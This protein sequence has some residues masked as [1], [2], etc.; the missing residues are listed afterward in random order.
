MKIDKAE[1]NARRENLLNSIS[2]DSV[3]ILASSKP[4]QRVSDTEY[5]Y[6]QDSNFYYLCGFD[7]PDSLIESTVTLIDSLSPAV[8]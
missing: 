7:E 5:S 3:I 6:R 2:P 4:K 1:F 8:I